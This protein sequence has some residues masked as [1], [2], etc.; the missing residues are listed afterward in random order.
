MDFDLAWTESAARA[1]EGAM[2]YLGERNPD[3]AKRIAKSILDRVE[4]LRSVPFMGKVY[5]KATRFEVRQVV[6]GRYRIL[7][8]VFEEA[9]L[10]EILAVWHGARGGEPELPD[11]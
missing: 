5:P 8:R 2:D 3:A 11:E 6:V 4:L 7:Y 1:F 10:V 9:N